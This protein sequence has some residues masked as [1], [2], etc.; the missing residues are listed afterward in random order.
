M[1]NRKNWKLSK[2]Y[3]EYRENVD[4]ISSGSVKVETTYLRYL[5]EWADE[6]SFHQAHKIRPSL[7]EYLTAI[8]LGSN[9]QSLSSMFVRKTLEAGRKFFTW[10]LDNYPEYRTIKRNWIQTLKSRRVEELPKQNKIPSFDEVMKIASAPA[11]TLVERRIRASIIFWF[12]SGIR[13]GAFVSLPIK[14]VDLDKRTVMQFPSMGVRTKNK[15]YATTTLYDIPELLKVV[16]D[17]DNEIRSALPGNSFWF[18]P[19]SP[20]TQELDP[21]YKEVG[22]H[23]DRIARKNLRAFL[24]KIGMTYYSPHK[25]RHAHIHYG[26]ERSKT[27]ADYKAVSMNVMH[28]S[29]DTTDEVYS[30]LDNEEIKARIQNID[31]QIDRKEENLGDQFELFQKFLEWQKSRG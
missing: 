8:R 16:R 5:L 13:V 2:A 22:E 20:D 6:V 19:L 28:A 10:V 3:I 11:G 25:F 31:K 27:M 12:L 21:K 7:P 30:R 14:G 15:K 9:K 24:S 18:A 23:R 4:L 1:I 26:L 17:W 29:M